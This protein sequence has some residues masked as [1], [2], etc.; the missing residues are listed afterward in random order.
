MIGVDSGCRVTCTLVLAHPWDLTAIKTEL[1]MISR[2]GF[3][4]LTG[5]NAQDD[6]VMHDPLWDAIPLLQ[7]LKGKAYDQLGSSG[8]G[9]HFLDV[10]EVETTGIYPDGR[11]LYALVSHSGSRGVGAQVGKYYSKLA[12]ENCPDDVPADYAYFDANSALGQ[13]YWKV[14]NLMGRYAQACH[15][16][17]HARFYLATAQDTLP[18]SFRAALGF[19]AQAETL[20]T[21]HAQVDGEL[22]LVP[23]WVL[24]NH[25]NFAWKMV[26]DGVTYYIHRKGATPAAQGQYGIIPG[27]SASNIYLVVGKGHPDSLESTSHG[28]G[29]LRSRSATTKL[30]DQA[31]VDAYYAAFGTETYGV[32][33]DETVFAYKDIDAVMAAQADLA[34][35]AATLKPIYVVMGGIETKSDDGD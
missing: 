20:Y 19:P 17:I 22:A 25:H 1:L 8:S 7:G 28:A 2:F 30:H 9:N 32:A 10:C 6:P 12:A 26:E 4:T 21:L 27:S 5:D 34:D 13:E 35:I 11:Q 24:E 33:P 16:L 23:L 3:A 15:H 14:M 31:K 29:R 18:V